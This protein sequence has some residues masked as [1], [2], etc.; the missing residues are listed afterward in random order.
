LGSKQPADH[1]TRD[2]CYLAEWKHIGYVSVPPVRAAGEQ[3]SDYRDHSAAT[4]SQLYL[5]KLPTPGRRGG[6]IDRRLGVAKSWSPWLE[7]IA[8]HLVWP[9]TAEWLLV[10]VQR[11]AAS[12][13][14]EWQ[15]PV[16]AVTGL[17]NLTGC[18]QP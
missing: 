2:V 12:Q 13:D 18:F 4:R 15:I 16:A 7:G 11:S 6:Q 14:D 17:Q 1:C 3:S 5:A 8:R 9:I 10:T